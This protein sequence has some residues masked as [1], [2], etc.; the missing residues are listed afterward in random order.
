MPTELWSKEQII[1][2]E[3]SQPPSSVSVNAQTDKVEDKIS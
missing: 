2:K 1:L 3:S